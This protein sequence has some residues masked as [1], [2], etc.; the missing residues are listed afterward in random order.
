MMTQIC[1]EEK[2]KQDYRE[3][4]PEWSIWCSLW[5]P[6]WQTGILVRRKAAEKKPKHVVRFWPGLSRYNAGVMKASILGLNHIR[7]AFPWLPQLMIT[8]SSYLYCFFPLLPSPKFFLRLPALRR[9]KEKKGNKSLIAHPFLWILHWQVAAML[10][11]HHWG[12]SDTCCLPGFGCPRSPAP[13]ARRLRKQCISWDAWRWRLL[14][15]TQLWNRQTGRHEVCRA[16][17]RLSSREFKMLYSKWL[18][19]TSSSHL[20]IP[21]ITWHHGDGKTVPCTSITDWWY[22]NLTGVI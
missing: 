2:N 4:L 11:P 21:A 19:T 18:T 1:D 20:T 15:R 13:E 9:K 14:S 7:S 3:K 17:E 10:R 6:R 8:I 5:E 12:R 16:A 22:E